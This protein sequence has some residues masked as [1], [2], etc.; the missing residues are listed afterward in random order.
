MAR[1]L[2]GFASKVER[3]AAHSPATPFFG[4]DRAHPAFVFG[5]FCGRPAAAIAGPGAAA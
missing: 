5:E 1:M 3:A 2:G 4:G